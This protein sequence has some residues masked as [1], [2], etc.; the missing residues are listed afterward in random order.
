MGYV[1]GGLGY[2]NPIR[3]VIEEAGELWKGRAIGCAVSIGMG[4]PSLKNVGQNLTDMA[5]TLL[6]IAT[7]TQQTAD[8]VKNEMHSKFGVQQQVYHRLNVQQGLSEIGLEEWKRFGEVKTVTGNYLNNHR[9][10]MEICATQLL[11][12]QRT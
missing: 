9:P 4:V 11:E 1:D 6:D 8:E 7:E 12:P 2:N 5:Q 3:K 10:E